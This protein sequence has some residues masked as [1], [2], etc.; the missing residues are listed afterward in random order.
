MGLVSVLIASCGGFSESRVPRHLC[1]DGNGISYDY[2]DPV[3]VAKKGCYQYGV[4]N[5]ELT[6]QL[7][8]STTTS[9]ATTSTLQE[10]ANWIYKNSRDVFVAPFALGVEKNDRFAFGFK[11]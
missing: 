7:A 8:H 9:N 3:Q 1:Y 5:V 6:Q 10:E 2:T 4:L 11:F